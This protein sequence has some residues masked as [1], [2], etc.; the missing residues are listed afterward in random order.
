[1]NGLATNR[2]ATP[3]RIARCLL[4]AALLALVP[5]GFV[6]S[7]EPLSVEAINS[8][9]L[10]AVERGQSETIPWNSADAAQLMITGEP[11]RRII[12]QV[13]PHQLENSEGGSAAIAITNDQC[14]Y[15][16]DE[17]VTWRRFSSGFLSQETRL[18]AGNSDVATILVRVGGTFQAQ[19]RNNRGVYSGVVELMVTPTSDDN[20]IITE[21]DPVS[22]GGPVDTQQTTPSHS[23]YRP[24]PVRPAH[25]DRQ[26]T[27]R[28]TR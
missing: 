24:Q 10:G 14:A 20:S 28:S 17:G 12:I 4:V 9:T 3:G 7:Q 25:A 27:E 1:M 21:G 6:Y 8:L 2:R 26:I 15:S 11:G 16:L 19:S 23:E 13:I 5:A 18:P 22:T